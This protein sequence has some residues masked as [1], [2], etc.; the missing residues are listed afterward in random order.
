MAIL[1]AFKGLRPPKGIAKEI[2]ARPYD[3]LNSTE[4]Y[5]EAKDNKYSLLHITKPEIDLSQDTDVHSE[6]VYRK[7]RENFDKFR[8]EGWLVQ[9]DKECLYIYAQTMFGKTQYGIVGCAAVEDY[10]NGIV[11]K[12]ELT[13]K[14]KEED[15]MKHVRV[16]NANMEPVFFTYPAVKELDS[17]NS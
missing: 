17:T 15:R 9:D 6:I 12:H 5:E 8:K 10:M 14:D 11:K 4:V 1:R 16:N 13:R 2:A 3:V 7:A